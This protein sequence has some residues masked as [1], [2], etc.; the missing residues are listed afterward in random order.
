MVPNRD[1][2]T[3]SRRL[4]KLADED[5]TPAQ[6]AA[7]ADAITRA[8][9]TL[10]R[11]AASV[12]VLRYPEDLPVVEAKDSI[13]EAIRDHQV[14]IVA[15]E[16]GSG[17]TTQIPKICL[18]LGRGVKGMV[19]HTQPRRIAARSVAERIAEELDVPLGESIGYQVRF[20]EQASEATLVKVMTDGILLNEIQRD[21]ELRRYDTIIIDEAHERSLNID[22]ILGYL[23]NLLPRRP[24]LKVIITSATIDPERFARH[25]ATN[26]VPAPIIEV[27]GRTY[28][29]E[30]R[31]RPLRWDERD[32]DQI[33]GVLDAITELTHEPAG[34]ILVFLSGEREIRDTADA[35]TGMRLPHTE[36]V[37]LFARLSA[38]EQHRIFSSHTGRRIVLATNVAETSLTVP[39]IRYVIDAGTARISRYSLRTKV[40]RLPIEPI[41]QASAQ[42]RAGRCGRL[43][44]G[45][46][47]RL[48]SEADFADRP[49]FTD[50]EILR[51]NLASVVLQMTALGLG[52]IASFP[53]VQPP[54]D[55]NIRDGVQLLTELG[56]IATDP[57]GGKRRLT[58]VGRKLVELPI[59]PRLARMVAA[60]SDLGCVREVIVIAAALSIQDPREHPLDA[61]EAAARAHARFADPSSDFLSY[62][63]LW[64]YLKEQQKKLSSSAFRRMCRRE[65]L[66][67]LRVRE[68]QDL[69]GQL[70]RAA[71]SQGIQ[72]SGTDAAPDTIHQALLVGL[73]SHIGARTAERNE[74]LGAR[75]AKFAVFPGSSLHKKPPAFVMAAELVETSRLWARVVAAI[76]PAWLEDLATHLLKRNY[77][78]P[79]WSTKRGATMAYEKVQ[80]YGVTIVASRLV[81]YAPIDPALSREMF[82]RHALVGGDWRTHHAFFFTNQ[83]RL[84]QASELE[85]R[86]RRRD[87]VVDEETLFQFYD[88][89]V[90]SGIVSAAHFDSW[91]KKARRRQPHLLDFDPAMLVTDAAQSVNMVAFPDTW[92]QGDLML[93]LDYTFDPGTA[94]DGVTV[95]IPVEI[96]NRVT[97]EGFDWLVPGLRDELITALIRTLPKP[98]RKHFVPAPNFAGLVAAALERD[99]ASPRGTITQ[100]VADE[101][102]SIGGF[103]VTAEEFEPERLPEHLRPSFRVLAS[104]EGAKN[105]VLGEGADLNALKA[106][107]SATTQTV[108]ATGA[109]EYER[110]GL[111][112]WPDALSTEGDDTRIPAVYEYG[113]AGMLVRGYPSLVVRSLADPKSM[114]D[115]KVL[116]QQEEQCIQMPMGV[117]QLVRFAIPSPLPQVRV[118]LDSSAK[119]ALVSS[120]YRDVPALLNDCVAAA[121]DHGVREIGVPWNG[122][123]FERLR[124]TIEPS[125]VDDTVVIVG[126]VVAVLQAARRIE[127][128]LKE[129]TSMTL[130][131]GLTDVRGQ[132]ARLVCD[133]FVTTF[134]SRRLPDIVRYLKA[135][136]IRLKKMP[137]HPHRDRQRQWQVEEATT[138]VESAIGALPG[139]HEKSDAVDDLRWLLEEYR[140][141][142][143][144]QEVGTAR[145]VSDKRIRAA[146]RE[147]N[148]SVS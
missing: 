126:D 65:Y 68:W 79:H 55:R 100:A 51:T 16:T 10:A 42:Q 71:G 114:V 83:E 4:R 52:D 116:A 146:I 47:I 103:T 137:D 21:R 23:K 15:G 111:T 67:Y 88:A 113:S 30:I 2:D 140:V 110:S 39:G 5:A 133:G 34:D 29:V 108:V 90:P 132:L 44:N 26:N 106:A 24:D 25:F 58:P 118:R 53:F 6:V 122:S 70:K 77:S 69:Y 130:L 78:E 8:Q 107:L 104:E 31:Y 128:V 91:W 119:L 63:G 64:N 17:K 125:L 36:V 97:P 1:F 35:V 124:Q 41:S 61:R 75:G 136:V 96:L 20:T 32:A 148:G 95:L 46:A 22:F 144:A 3:L 37:P 139:G 57:T 80:L 59:D 45:I 98:V 72:I 60:A 62:L 43:A 18:E 19:G 135:A 33:Q 74:Y 84:T 81:N 82:I 142:L 120:P 147:L 56:A 105:R 50:P 141:S 76:D 85:N 27:S 123:D 38:A 7:L 9:A 54:N 134:G 102:T 92:Q 12:P 73:L 87:I 14:V 109:V 115:L 112:T 89:R 99:Y 143:W 48:Y 131:S 49:P 101:L 13:L 127:R 93:P 117:R 86:A 28:P 40:Q 129:T 121:I 145:P 138:A 66:N 11:R 94:T